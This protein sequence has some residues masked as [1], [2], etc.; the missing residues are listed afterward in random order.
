MEAGDIYSTRIV[1]TVCAVTQTDEDGGLLDN[2][3]DDEQW[4]MEQE[5]LSIYE[6]PAVNDAVTES[7]AEVG[8]SDA[9][10]DAGALP[11]ITTTLIDN[12]E[13]QQQS[14]V[15]MIPDT[16]V[17]EQQ[18]LPLNPVTQVTNQIANAGNLIMALPTDLQQQNAA[19]MANPTIPILS[20]VYPTGQIDGGSASVITDGLTEYMYLNVPADPTL[21]APPI[22]DTRSPVLLLSNNIE[23]GTV[24]AN[25]VFDHLYTRQQQITFQTPVT[26]LTTDVSSLLTTGQHPGMEVI[27]TGMIGAD[28]CLSEQQ[29]TSKTKDEKL[30]ICEVEGCGRT[31]SSASNFKYHKD[32]HAG[33]KSLTCDFEGCGRKFAWPAHLAYHQFTH[34]NERKFEC[35]IEGCDKRFY[36]SQRR[37]VHMRTH[38]GVRPFV[39][40]ETGCGKAFTTAGN[41]KNHSRIHSGEKPY[42]C[43]Y[44]NCKKAFAELS[45]LKKHRTVH[46][47]KKAYS[48]QNCGK[49]FTQVGSRNIH[50]KRCNVKNTTDA[51]Q[52]TQDNR[53]TTETTELFPFENSEVL[54]YQDGDD[55]GV[56]DVQS[57]T[58]IEADGTIQTTDDNYEENQNVVIDHIVDLLQDEIQCQKEI[59]VGS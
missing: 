16:T 53:T 19:C 15:A 59:H 46:T 30:L 4:L 38:S 40:S 50:T 48:C 49:T 22:I 23:K 56:F 2:C 11:P 24:E 9:A 33:Q 39:C 29:Q 36:T 54:V 27:T 55:T 13:P 31:F 32:K 20:Y 42:K 43:E 52:S 34:M 17:C 41:L 21:I 18:Y 7:A 51:Q 6:P 12:N 26:N 10:V 37:D 14:I 45:S 35:K 3:D 8:Y 5:N 28:Q 58:T 1:N 47:G 57:E 25:V 44:E